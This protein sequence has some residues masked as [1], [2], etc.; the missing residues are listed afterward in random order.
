MR[1]G[2]PH[3]LRQPITWR[4]AYPCEQCAPF[5]PPR[6][7]RW[8]IALTVDYR[9]RLPRLSE[10]AI[11]PPRLPKPPEVS[12]EVRERVVRAFAAWREAGEQMA[13]AVRPAMT[14]LAEG[15][16]RLQMSAPRIEVGPINVETN[17]YAV[18]VRQEARLALDAAAR[19]SLRK[20][21]RIV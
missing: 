10:V 12:P 2:C 16:A 11:E 21:P 7:P 18:R 4:T 1:V 8:A 15:G 6:W 14:A 5:G 17:T 20:M 9:P 19:E 13:E 3:R